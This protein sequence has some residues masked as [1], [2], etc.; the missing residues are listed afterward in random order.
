MSDCCQNKTKNP[1]PVKEMTL[2]DM[3]KN[4]FSFDSKPAET[5]TKDSCR[6]QKNGQNKSAK[7][8]C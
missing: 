2:K 8:C 4:A 6:C 1:E 5:K 7:A 3:F